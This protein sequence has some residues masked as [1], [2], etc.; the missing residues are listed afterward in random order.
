MFKQ[1]ALPSEKEMLNAHFGRSQAFTL[2]TIEDGEV[3]GKIV[4][5]T[6]G[7]EHQHSGIAEFLKSKGVEVVI[8][9]GI[10]PGAISG[11]ES[12]GLEVLRGANGT[13]EE[14]AAAYAKGRLITSDAVCNHD[15]D[16][17]H[18]H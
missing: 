8:C 9:G 4:L 5:D 12:A 2:F 17:S 14:V 13:V 11:L 16:H 3:S 10:G 1:I 6:K 15:H 7:L 18:Q